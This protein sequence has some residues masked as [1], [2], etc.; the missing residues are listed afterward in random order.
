MTTDRITKNRRSL[1]G[2]F[3][4]S[5]FSSILFQ[6]M[7]KLFKQNANRVERAILECYNSIAGTMPEREYMTD[8]CHAGAVIN[9]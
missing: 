3:F 9:K 6:N 5:Q 1:G 8:R 7:D 2:F 4:F